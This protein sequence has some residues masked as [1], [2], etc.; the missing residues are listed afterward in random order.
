MIFLISIVKSITGEP[1]AWENIQCS[2]A[3]VTSDRGLISKIYRELIQLNKRKINSPIKQ[4]AKDLN[5]H[6]SKVDTQKAKRHMKTYSKSL[7]IRKM[8]VKTPMK[9]HLPPVKMA[10]INKSTNHKSWQGC[11]EKGTLV[12]CWWEC[13]LVQPL[14][15]TV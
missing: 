7:I 12:H 8:Q 11:R 10:I 6:S 5:R 13:R 3:N 2:F 1:C 9:Y 14:W 4:W 15:R